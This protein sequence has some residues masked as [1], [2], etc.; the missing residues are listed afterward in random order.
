MF[1]NILVPVDL[2]H[3]DQLGRALAAAADLSRHYGAPVRYV[4]VTAQTP[5]AEARTPRQFAEKLDAFARAQ[6][7]EHGIETSARSYASHDPAIDINSTLLAA[8][9]EAGAD[10][11]VM[12]SHVPDAADYLWP[13]HG[14]SVASHSQASVFVVR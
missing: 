3:I 11:V 12:A 14:G 6:A 4:A 1:R 13:S 9:D 7:E 2:A 8:I 5:T 10:L